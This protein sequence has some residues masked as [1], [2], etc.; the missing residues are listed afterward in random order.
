M[1]AGTRWR[2]NSPASLT[3]VCPALA[4]A[5]Y[6]ATTWAFCA[7]RSTMRPFPS[8]P[9]WPPT[10][11]MTG[12]KQSASG[13]LLPSSQSAGSIG[14]GGDGVKGLYPLSPHRQFGE[15][16]G[17]VSPVPRQQLVCL[18]QSVRS[19]NEVSDHVLSGL[20]ARSA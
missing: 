14:A 5:E 20:D 1:P 3:T 18:H 17:V 8:S 10:T 6:L 2:A 16:G 15:V 13:G 19:D 12:I 7:S 9:H 11:T 4:P